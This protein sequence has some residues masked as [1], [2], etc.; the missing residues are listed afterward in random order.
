MDA[1]SNV[2][3]SADCTCDLVTARSGEIVNAINPAS[4]AI[5][6][7]ISVA[8]CWI[9]IAQI[10]RSQ[11]C[12]SARKIASEYASPHALLDDRGHLLAGQSGGQFVKVT[13]HRLKQRQEWLAT[14][15]A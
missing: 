10:L 1:I 2:G 9:V 4:A 5:V 7:R 11:V 14:G 15:A 6:I 3:R 8:K 12:N 13:I